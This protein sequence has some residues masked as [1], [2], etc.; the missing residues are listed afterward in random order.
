MTSPNPEDAW[1]IDGAGWLPGARRVPSA[2]RDDRPPD[3]AIDLIVLHAISLPPGEFGGCAVEDFFT[4]RLDVSAHPFFESLAGRR[5][6]AHFFIRRDASIVQ[7]VSCLDRAWHA[8]VSCWRGRSSCNDFSIGIEI[9][10]DDKTPFDPRQYVSLDRVLAAL[11]AHYPGAAIAGHADIA[12]GRKT[13]PGPFFD[14]RRLRGVS[15]TS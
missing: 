13:D 9:E 2:H 6:S 14:W 3:A 15:A 8:G 5:V 11:L 1:C 7:F 10:G 12:P 4:G